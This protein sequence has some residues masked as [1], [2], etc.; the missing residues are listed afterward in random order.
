MKRKIFCVY[1]S[2]AEN[3]GLPFVFDNRA[4]A[5]RGFEQVAN[6]G[7]NNISLYPADFTLFEVGEWD[8]LAGCAS[9]YESKISL[10]LAVEY[11]KT[12]AVPVNN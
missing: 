7:K 5:V 6:D 8:M 1:D 2:K 9:M 3:F 12:G 4:E 11:K 10:G